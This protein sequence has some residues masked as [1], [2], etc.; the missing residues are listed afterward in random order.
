MTH[1]SGT[2]RLFIE[3]FLALSSHRNVFAPAAIVPS[4]MDQIFVSKLYAGRPC[5]LD[6]WGK[7]CP[8]PIVTSFSCKGSIADAA[9]ADEI[10]V[11]YST[12]ATSFRNHIAGNKFDTSLAVAHDLAA[13]ATRA[14]SKHALIRVEK[15]GGFLHAAAIGSE[16]EWCG[17]KSQRT[18]RSLI[19][20]LPRMHHRC[21]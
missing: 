5:R 7:T 12:I 8:Q 17:W 21:S 1:I 15:P 2:L 9:A 13:L 3:N 10:S 20:T 4:T 16:V 6:R 11:C 18:A 19:V 14:G